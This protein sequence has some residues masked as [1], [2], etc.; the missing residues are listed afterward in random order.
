MNTTTPD[1]Q[2]VTVFAHEFTFTN[3]QTVQIDVWP[4]LGDNSMCYGEG[5]DA[6]WRF[7]Y[8]RRE[9]FQEIYMHNVNGHLMREEQ[10]IYVSPEETKRRVKDMRD[11]QLRLRRR[12]IVRESEPDGAS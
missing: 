6:Y 3:G 1:D 8:P 5:R 10:R 4:S 7:G 9:E 12:E 11:E 2:K